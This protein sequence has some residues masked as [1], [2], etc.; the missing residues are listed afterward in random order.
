MVKQ[1][2]CGKKEVTDHKYRPTLLT[3]ALDSY[4]PKH[5][6]LPTYICVVWAERIPFPRQPTM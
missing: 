6:F 1:A 2:R 5:T 3:E 4:E